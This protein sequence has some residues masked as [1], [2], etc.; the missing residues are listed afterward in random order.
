[1]AGVI[2][3]TLLRPDATGRD[4]D[5]VCDEA[6]QYGF[7]TVC[8]NA[9]WVAH[10]RRR[11]A[12][13]PVGVCSVVGFPFGATTPDVKQY[14]ARRALADGASEIDMVINVGALKSGDRP[15]V[16]C[17][18]EG[19]VQACRRDH[20]LSKVI[21]ET[22]LL[23]DDEKRIAC[24]LAKVAGADFVKTSTGFGPG[25]ATVADVAL[26]REVVGSQIGVKAAGG[27]RDYNAFKAMAE[28]GASRIGASAGI[29]IVHQ[30]RTGQ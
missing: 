8:L 11:L 26:M 21:I 6:A 2:D 14:E 10:A 27:I 19:V 30:A 25:G 22:A 20:A 13:A 16:Q 9:T 28:A 24:S 3:H 4:I 12:D 5:K 18:I 23:T 7:V 15:L 17:D 1:M 29:R